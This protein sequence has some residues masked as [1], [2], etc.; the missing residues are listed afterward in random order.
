MSASS[1]EAT[2]A[3]APGM[4]R[5]RGPGALTGD[6]R[7]TVE[8][9]RL[10]AATDFKLRFFD[11]VLGYL[12]TLLRPLLFFGVLYA[13]FSLVLDIGE[14]VEFYPVLLLSGM[15]LFLYF[16]ETTTNALRSVVDR[17]ELVR[18][19]HFPRIVIPLASSTTSLFFLGTNLV[20]VFIFMAFS[21]VEVRPSWL[22]LPL[23]VGV[24]V[25]LATGVSMLISAV[26]VFVRDL[27][28]IWNVVTQALFYITPVLFPI[29]I[30]QRESPEAAELLLL[31]PLAAI[32][33][34][35]RHAMVDSAAP[36]AA[37]AIGGVGWLL[38]PGGL[39]AAAFVSGYLVFDRLAPRIADEL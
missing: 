34:Q 16:S 10:L 11:S 4:T 32:I 5:I 29:E 14:G 30:V 39:V 7:R 2:G 13:V 21:G 26:Y 22:Q 18:K 38:V 28:P 27:D 9:T 33:Q 31:N 19:I 8:L 3:P 36:T 35:F 20:A 37:E 12:W 1:P 25:I 6:W 23:I 24:L 17:Q 15:V